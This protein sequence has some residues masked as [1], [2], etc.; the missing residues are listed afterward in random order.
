[1]CFM[2]GMI[3]DAGPKFYVVW[4]QTLYMTKVKVMDLEFLYWNFV[5]K[6]L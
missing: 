4:S 3:I 1:M 6:F 2:Y 5:F